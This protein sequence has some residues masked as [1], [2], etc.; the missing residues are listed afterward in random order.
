MTDSAVPVVDAVSVKQQKKVPLYAP[1]NRVYPK[2][3]SG[4]FRRLK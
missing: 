2:R 3:V 1:R 4:T